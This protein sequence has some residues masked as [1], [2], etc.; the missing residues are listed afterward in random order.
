MC[1]DRVSGFE[2]EVNGDT[3]RRGGAQKKKKKG[4]VSGVVLPDKE[5]VR[6]KSRRA[7]ES[8]G[9]PGEDEGSTYAGQETPKKKS[10]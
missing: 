6:E 9:H 10:F 5:T 4:G 1:I 7:S 8:F 3:K 2:Q